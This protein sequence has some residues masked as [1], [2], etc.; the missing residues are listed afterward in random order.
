MFDSGG[1]ECVRD[2]VLDVPATKGCVNEGH[3]KERFLTVFFV[4]KYDV[5][6]TYVRSVK[7][8]QRL[9]SRLHPTYTESDS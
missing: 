6:V 4:W 5:S 2:L 3:W 1:L 8:T 7:V 9:Q